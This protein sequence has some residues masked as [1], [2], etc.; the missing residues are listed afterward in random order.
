MPS[1][2]RHYDDT[3]YEVSFITEIANV[4]RPRVCTLLNARFTHTRSTHKITTLF[5]Q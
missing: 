3:K 5:I 1:K 2:V 4:T